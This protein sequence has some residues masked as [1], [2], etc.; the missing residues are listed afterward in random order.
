MT[1][2]ILYIKYC[3]VIDDV[4]QELKQRGY[5]MIGISSIDITVDGFVQ[6]C[7]EKKVALVLGI[8]FSPEIAYL[9]SKIMIPYLNWTIDPL[10]F[11]RKEL[12]DGTNPENCLC[13]VHD[14]NMVDFFQNL[15]LHAI[16]L[17]LAAPTFRRQ[18]FKNKD[19]L[20]PYF[21]DVSFVGV[22][23]NKELI[24]L[25][26][27]LTEITNKDICYETILS[28]TKLSNKVA[29]NPKYS[30]IEF[31]GG[32]DILPISLQNSNI[33]SEE[34]DLIL[35]HIDGALASI[36]RKNA[37]SILKDSKHVIHIW[38]DEGWIDEHVGYKGFAEH[39][40]EL[41][42]IYCASKINLDIPRLYQKNI[43]NMRIF[44]ILAAGGF[45][46]T[47]QND[48]LSTYF[49]VGTHIAVYTSQK[50]LLERISWW[51][52]RPTERFKIA[53]EGREH[54]LKNHLISHRV[55]YMLSY[56][57]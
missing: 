38:G 25:E 41:T 3:L 23:M 13:F 47:E 6:L 51:L 46:L 32:W 48:E 56:I 2:C 19:I 36:H 8:N 1:R 28:I 9:C 43:L 11:N 44:D 12:I 10:P 4:V 40:E 35:Y 45:V 17:P 18:P 49:E 22:S 16:H 14:P 5:K 52:D 20:A 31:M 26:N 30:G 39:G 21:C 29:H 34:K 15:G 37:I 54:V 53:K 42:K 57:K 7:K 24:S 33:N 50:D 27:I 55:D